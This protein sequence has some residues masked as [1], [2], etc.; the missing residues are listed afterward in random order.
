MMVKLAGSL[1]VLASSIAAAITVLRGQR[2]ELQ[3]LSGLAAALEQMEGE[4]R[5]NRTPM[6]R[7]LERLG[8]RRG[9][10]AD[11]FRLVSAAICR[12]GDLGMA[13][14]DAVTEA[15]IPAREKLIFRETGEDLTGDEEK[16][17]RSLRAAAERL[18]HGLDER[19]RHQADRERRSAAVCLSGGA[20]MVILLI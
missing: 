9:P 17:C 5:L 18:R 15:A 4:I 16:A 6:L 20:L 14:R 7:I 10:E 12:G 8:G 3:L 11:F 1:C 2:R 19:C 13:W